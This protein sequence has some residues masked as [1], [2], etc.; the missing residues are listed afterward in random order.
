MIATKSS[1]VQPK[2]SFSKYDGIV[3]GGQP[4]RYF[5]T[6]EEGH[7]FVSAESTGVPQ[8]MSNG[9][10]SR[11]L[12]LGNFKCTPNEHQPEHL[13]E[14]ILPAGDL[15]SLKSS[16]SQ[17]KASVRHAAV[18]AFQELLRD[19]KKD[20]QR[21]EVSVRRHLGAIK[22]RVG[23]ILAE[24]R[25]EDDD[26]NLAVPK[27]L[28]AKTLLTWERKYRR[29]GL[30]GLYGR[31][32]DRGN[33][34][35][36]L[37]ADELMLMAKIVSQYLDDKCPSQAIIYRDVKCAFLAD[38]ERRRAEGQPEICCPSRETVRQAIKKLNPFDVTL[39][40]KGRAA[41]NNQFAPLGMGNQ[42]GRPM[43]RVEFDEWESDVISSYVRKRAAPS[44][45][46]RGKE[47]ARPRQKEGA[48]VDHCRHLLRNPLHCR[49][50]HFPHAKLPERSARHR[51]DDAGQ[52]RMG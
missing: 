33:R 30:A 42:I 10:I 45:D 48:L 28:G 31:I 20:V 39:T 29:F 32:E 41:A 12:S 40:R 34:D 14:R 8:V 36:R 46:R 44:P 11:Y 23:E 4:H 21:T 38:N 22:F 35:R 1:P 51:N 47:G 27:R 3:I 2:F 37:T 52:G 6:R 19:E 18:L 43:Q 13:R 49:D 26:E 17:R 16:N 24:G 7:I 50:G 15:L 5:E 25:P 9:E